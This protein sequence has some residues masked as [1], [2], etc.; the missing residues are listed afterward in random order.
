LRTTSSVLFAERMGS[1]HPEGTL[2]VDGSAVPSASPKWLVLF[3]FLLGIAGGTQQFLLGALSKHVGIT[4]AAGVSVSV[5][6]IMLAAIGAYMI[7]T[8][9]KP[10]TSGPLTSGN[11]QPSRLRDAGVAVA[12]LVIGIAYLWIFGL[13]QPWYLYAPGLLGLSLVSGLAYAVPRLGTG[14]TFAGVVAGQMAASLMFDRFGMLG[15]RSIPIS[16]MRTLGGLALIGGV[17]WV[18]GGKKQ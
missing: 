12:F 10:F 17:G 18:V 7:A 4:V 6:L 11:L 9:Q 15:L 1:V 13:G 3:V 2:R 8:N 16:P 14:A 5:A